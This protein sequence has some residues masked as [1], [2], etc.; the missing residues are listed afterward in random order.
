MQ[1]FKRRVREMKIT[2]ILTEKQLNKIARK[3]LKKH[4]EMEDE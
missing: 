1:K 4:K 3:W 2:R